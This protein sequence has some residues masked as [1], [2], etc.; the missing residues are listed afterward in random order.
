MSGLAGHARSGQGGGNISKSNVARGIE[1]AKGGKP[2]ESADESESP[3]T[4]TS[5][6]AS[7]DASSEAPAKK[8]LAD[9]ARSGV[10]KMATDP[11]KQPSVASNIPGSGTQGVPP[12]EADEMGAFAR[13]GN[14]DMIP[15]I[16]AAQTGLATH[17]PAVVS[18]LARM[19]G[20]VRL[21]P[22]QFRAWAHPKDASPEASTQVTS[23]AGKPGSLPAPAPKVY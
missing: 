19:G 14:A 7:S 4:P 12:A 6:D 10:E 18:S 1:K 23:Q 20:Q 17:G 11:D 9:F 2:W 3:T 21:A 22:G 13:R 15:R 5:S 16:V 8:S